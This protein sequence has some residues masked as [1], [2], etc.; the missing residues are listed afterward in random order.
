M[1]QDFDPILIEVLKNELTAV[2]EEMG[3]TMKRT[4]AVRAS[5]AARSQSTANGAFC[6]MGG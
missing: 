5:S 6:M 4:A 2:A 3:M 1:K